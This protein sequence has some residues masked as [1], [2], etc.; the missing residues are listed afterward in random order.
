MRISIRP[1]RSS[2]PEKGVVMSRTKLALTMAGAAVA[3]AVAGWA[4]GVMF[5]P[6]SGK[7]SWR[8]IAWRTDGQWRSAARA[9]RRLFKRAATCA[10][11]ELESRKT[12]VM[13][14]V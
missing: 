5:P 8:R 4:L 6:A 12:H 1:R 2:C 14:A 3:A 7:E 11:E 9:S 13:G 10:R